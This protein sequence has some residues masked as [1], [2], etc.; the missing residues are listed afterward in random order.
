MMKEAKP[1]G[2]RLMLAGTGAGTQTSP[3]DEIKALA[4]LQSIYRN[5][6]EAM[7]ARMRAAIESLPY[8]NPKLSAVAHGHFDGTDFATQLEKAIERSRQP[9]LLPPPTIDHEPAVSAEEMKRPFS[10]FRRW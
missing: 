9:T 3:E 6:M 5:P 10:T 7:P 1:N 2:N 4:Y 8:E